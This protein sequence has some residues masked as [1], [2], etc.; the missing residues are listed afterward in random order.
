MKGEFTMD[1]IEKTKKFG[2]RDE[3]M[4]SLRQERNLAGADMSELDLSGIKLMGLNMKG[5]DLHG[6]N[7][8]QATLAGADMS[9]V[10]LTNAHLDKA[11]IAG[12]S[13][14]AAN[15]RGATLNEAQVA[16][17]DM[18]D[19]DLTGAD[20]SQSKLMGVGVR[21]ADFSKVKTTDARA[22]VNWADAKVQPAELPE[23]LTPPRWL[24]FLFL[25]VGITLLVFFLRRRKNKAD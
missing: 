17:V 23:P 10:N 20:L 8:T 6:S 16:G 2:S 15:L 7:L 25:G 1:V 21:G 4:E 14:R 19:A 11:R 24:P 9:E 5:A 12:A 18:Q 22:A 3:I 13:L